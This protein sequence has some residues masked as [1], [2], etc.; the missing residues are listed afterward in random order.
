[1]N[2]LACSLLIIATVAFAQDRGTL[3]ATITG[4]SGA[5]VPGTTANR[6]RQW[7]FGEGIYKASSD[8]GVLG[9]LP[10]NQPL[11]SRQLPCRPPTSPS[12]A[13]VP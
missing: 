5:A 10:S 11:L 1:V 8:F 13:A 4:S 9:G 12:R 6:L 2:R 3:S 7:H